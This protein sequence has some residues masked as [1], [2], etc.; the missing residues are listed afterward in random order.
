MWPC[1]ETRPVSL[2]D[3]YWW[4]GWANGVFD[5]QAVCLFQRMRSTGQH[6]VGHVNIVQY[7]DDLVIHILIK[8]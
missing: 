7:V 5:E 1:S 2:F 4:L 6:R 8:K 3:P